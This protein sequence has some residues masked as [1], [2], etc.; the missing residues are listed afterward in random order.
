MS[1]SR[2]QVDPRYTKGARLEIL[3][4]L[5]GVLVPLAQVPDP[6]FAQK[7]VGDGVSVD[8]TSAEVLAPVT[9][10]V[11]QLHEAKHALTI[12][13]E[14]GVEVLIHVG[15]DT[16]A[17]RGDG[18]KVLVQRGD[19]V[20]A[21]QTVVTFDLDRIAC[22]ARSL[23]T[24]IIIANGERVREL[25][26]ATGAVR[27]GRDAVLVLELA[28]TGSGAPVVPAEAEVFFSKRVVLPNSAG[29]HA[30]PSAVL[31][32][33]ARQFQAEV[34][35]LRGAEEA[36]AKSVV[37]LMALSTR[38]GDIVQLRA[39]G[40]DAERAVQVLV[41]V[42]TMGCGE[43]PGDAPAPPNLATPR[44]H[45]P[46]PARSPDGSLGLTGE[47]ASPGLVIGRVVR[48]QHDEYAIEK[49]G[50]GSAEERPRLDIALREAERQLE[51]LAASG[52]LRA[53][54]EIAGAQREL[55][56]DLELIG[57]AAALIDEGNSAAFAWRAAYESQAGRLDTLVNG[58]LRERAADIRDVGR[59]VLS[60]LAERTPARI[61]LPEAAILMANDL[62]PSGLLSLDRSKV[63]GVCTTKGGST[64]HVAILARSLGLPTICGIDE[65][66]LE[67]APGMPVVLDATHGVLW[68]QPTES[69]LAEARENIARDAKRKAV[70]LAG[71][72]K[73][74]TTTD[75]RC[76]EVAANV[77]NAADIREALALGAEGVGLLRSEFLFEDRSSAPSEAEQTEAYC[78]AAEALG[79][80]R[81]LVVRTLDVGGDKPLAYLPLP[82]E[83]NPFLGMRGV[84]VSLDQPELFRAQLRAILQA[85]PLCRLHVMFP[86]VSGLDELR[87]AKKILREEARDLHH[88]VKVGI[89]IEVP[90]AAVLAGTLAAEADFFSIGTNDLTQYTLAL[91]RGHTKLAKRADALHPAVLKM[92]ALTVEG[93]RRHGRPVSVCGSVTSDIAAVAALIGLG[94]DKLSVPPPSIP[95]IKAQIRRLSYADCRAV[96]AELLGLAT[97]AEVRTRLDDLV[98]PQP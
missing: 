91:D 50:K 19:W 47:S 16:V 65:I 27:A 43:R 9:G 12:T 76:I 33:R 36:N 97:A 25:R 14:S 78:A 32:A 86:M 29:L 20:E 55:L 51:R 54:A 79:S 49:E 30:R 3:A 85:A 96:A 8:P 28:V 35:L 75:G 41:E 42:I 63:V 62:T 11:T 6:V 94:V 67:L 2:C 23:L 37:S 95:A 61:E 40:T 18:F 5:S 83:E 92:V 66:S 44:G 82:A 68:H 87:A 4:P 48:Y 38:Y 98:P 74:A 1:A 77:R 26:P 52:H 70:E 64:S 22:R 89:M 58:L 71:A 39:S 80:E 81:S 88:E 60:L 90:S 24:Q 7:L 84:R 34:R 93:A 72:F 69:K 21:G 73:S 13:T 59:R 31:S 56:H 10:T 57:G 17:L 15:V 45:E 53:G 46:R